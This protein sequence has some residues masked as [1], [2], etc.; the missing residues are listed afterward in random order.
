MGSEKH[1][2]SIRSAPSPDETGTVSSHDGTTIAFQVFGKDGPVLLMGNGVGVGFVGLARQIELFRGRRRVVCWDYRGTFDSGVPGPAGLSMVAH[3]GD[4]LAVLSHL[5]ATQASY[6]G[7]SMGVQVGFEIARQRPLLLDRLVGIGGVAGNPFKVALP[8]LGIDRLVPGAL[9]VVAR[10]AGRL[11]PVVRAVV[12]REAFLRA[13]IAAGY[14]R[15]HADRD[16]FLA[17]ARGVA[18]H[19]L[20]VYL[21]TIAEMG[22]HD[23]EDTLPDLRCPLLLVNG[24]LDQM[25]PVPE[26]RRLATL[27][28]RGGVHVVDGASHFV[29]IEAPAQVNWA[30]ER[31]LLSGDPNPPPPRPG[32]GGAGC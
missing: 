22:R 27:A 26:L 15:P 21:T 24:S 14:V 5:E 3:A 19:D 10:F 25:I 29:T 7:W 20:R 31:F 23:V 18:N 6:V 11:S 12:E 16:V 13:A 28:P 30:I 2:Q 9:D 8:M 32:L 1:W 4:G 17:M